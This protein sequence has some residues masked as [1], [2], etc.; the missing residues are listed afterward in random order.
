MNS[1]MEAMCGERDNTMDQ[2]EQNEKLW[3][4]RYQKKSDEVT[5]ILKLHEQ[6]KEDNRDALIQIDK[7]VKRIRQLQGEQERTDKD[8]RER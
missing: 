4:E 8:G 6:V 7:L 5:A 2:F 1:K 3:K